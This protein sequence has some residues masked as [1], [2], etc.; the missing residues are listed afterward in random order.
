MT[1]K[2][3]E[4]GNPGGKWRPGQSGNPNGRPKS[5]PFKDAL[6]RILKAMGEGETDRGL[7]QLAAAIVAKAQTGDVAA[8]KE[9][10]DRYE[11]K[12]PTPIGGTDEV[13]GIKGIAWLDPELGAPAS[14]NA[15]LEGND[16]KELH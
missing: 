5:R 7:D 9:I 15:E 6:D 13:P 1:W 8:Y 12:V 3:G 2:K 16:S 14:D 11:G 4:S 10:A